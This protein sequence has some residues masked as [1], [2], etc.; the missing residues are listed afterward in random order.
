VSEVQSSGG[1]SKMTFILIV[2]CQLLLIVGKLCGQMNDV[3]WLEVM[4]I[5][6]FM[7]I[8]LIGIYL[9]KRFGKKGES[10]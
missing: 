3:G 1:K 7:A 8:S 10:R 9:H 5:T 6:I 2:A 4:S